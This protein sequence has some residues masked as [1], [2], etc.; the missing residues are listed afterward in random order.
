MEEAIRAMGLCPDPA[1]DADPN[2][3]DEC[4]RRAEL[5]DG[6]MVCRCGVVFG[7]FLDSSPEPGRWGASNR[8]RHCMTASVLYPGAATYM[9]ARS[10]ECRKAIRAQSWGSAAGVRQLCKGLTT[11]VSEASHLGLC[12]SVTTRAKHLY[13]D[14]LADP[15]LKGTRRAG[16]VEG[17]LYAALQSQGGARTVEELQSCAAAGT[18]GVKRVMKIVSAK[19]IATS[20]C[21]VRA[22]VERRADKLAQLFQDA[23]VAERFQKTVA[24]AADVMDRAGVV[25][26]YKPPARAA[27]CVVAAAS[28]PVDRR[29]VARIMEVSVNTAAKCLAEMGPYRQLIVNMASV[30]AA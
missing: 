18:V 27:A 24:A 14:V 1:C 13:V 2:V 3:C 9:T 22:Y 25:T 8:E 29:A 5:S 28:A 20:G 7:R 6:V 26:R 11:I 16:L 30:S 23:E 17:C 4:G 10:Q 21:S 19:D 15:H 12:E